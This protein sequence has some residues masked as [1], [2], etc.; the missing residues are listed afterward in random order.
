MKGIFNKIA[1]LIVS[2][3]FFTSL[4]SNSLLAS[5]RIRYNHE[6]MNRAELAYQ[7]P[8]P[9]DKRKSLAT[10]GPEDVFPTQADDNN[11]QP[12]Q[13]NKRA[14]AR[15]TSATRSRPAPI[16]TPVKPAEPAPAPTEPPPQATA[17][18]DPTPL[19]APSATPT[20][21]VANLAQEDASQQQI[22]SQ[23]P[24]TRMSLQNLAILTILVSTALVF[25]LLKLMAKF[26][27][28]SG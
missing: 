21:A 10:Y 20:A 2:S 4:A 25:V 15:Q 14:G 27:E 5:A 6:T 23:Q 22:T 19:P 12:R 26:R 7:Q 11:R 13:R 16:T 18:V 17:P 28:G 8:L 1:L 3:L 9:P 24:G